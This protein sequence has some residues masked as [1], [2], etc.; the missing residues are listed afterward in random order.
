VPL[1]VR[2]VVCYGASHRSIL[3]L[4]LV[5]GLGAFAEGGL[6]RWL[7]AGTKF[8]CSVMTD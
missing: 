4:P 6:R 1:R 7:V 5:S 3:F 8:A 2:V